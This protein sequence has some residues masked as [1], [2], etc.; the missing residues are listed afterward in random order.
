[1]GAISS[2]LFTVIVLLASYITTYFMGAL[3]EPST[4][5]F[6]SS[7]SY[8][9]ISP[10][11]VGKDLIRAALRILKEESGLNIDND[12]LFSRSRPKVNLS[13]GVA[14]GPPGFLKRLVKRFSELS[15]NLVP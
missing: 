13:P 10:F 3:E 8:Y 9:Y 5:S 4:S 12:S 11:D 6:Y 15:L 7:Y 14:P 1:M 2:V